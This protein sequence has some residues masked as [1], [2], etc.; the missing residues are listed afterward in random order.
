MLDYVQDLRLDTM[1]RMDDVKMLIFKGL[2]TEEIVTLL[3]LNIKTVENHKTALFATY[4][5][6][7]SIA[8]FRQCFLLGEREEQ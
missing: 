1:G 7:S 4:G 6:K 2:R 5:V 3:R 8:L